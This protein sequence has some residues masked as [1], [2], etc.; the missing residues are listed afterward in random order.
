MINDQRPPPP[1][2]ATMRRSLADIIGWPL[3][4]GGVTVYAGMVVGSHPK[5]LPALLVLAAVGGLVIAVREMTPARVRGRRVACGH[6]PACNYDLCHRPELGCSEC[7]WN[8][9]APIAAAMMPP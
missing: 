8:R 3:L 9:S 1:N 2:I 7:G 4:L 6:C 5:E